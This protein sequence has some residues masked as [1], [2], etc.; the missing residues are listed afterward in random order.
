VQVLYDQDEVS[1]AEEESESEA[2]V[3][4]KKQI[5]QKQLEQVRALVIEHY[6]K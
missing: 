1:T 4:T 5:G 2:E 3:E 6:Q